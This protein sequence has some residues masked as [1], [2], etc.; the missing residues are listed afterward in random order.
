MAL[1]EEFRRQAALKFINRGRGR[2]ETERVA[3]EVGVSVTTLHE[4]VNR[5]GIRSDMPREKKRP[6]DLSPAEKF[7]AVVDYEHLPEEK[8]GEFL[9]STG[10]HSETIEA[11]KQAIEKSLETPSKKSSKNAGSNTENQR[12]R[13]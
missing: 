5:C 7:K 12:T 6:R 9:R 1:T 8:R 11:W 4:W 2:H 13:A 3:K 10:L